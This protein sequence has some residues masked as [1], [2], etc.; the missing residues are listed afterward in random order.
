[1]HT[2]H[3]YAFLLVKMEV[4]WSVCRKLYSACI[5]V[6]SM[7]LVCFMKPEF[8]MTIPISFCENLMCSLVVRC[9]TCL[10]GYSCVLVIWL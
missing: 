4:P 8:R 5:L 7:L 2:M 9:R 10:W 1:M 3:N 6:S